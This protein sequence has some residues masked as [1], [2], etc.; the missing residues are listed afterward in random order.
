MKKI[1]N[2]LL[3]TSSVLILQVQSIAVLSNLDL[4]NDI[5]SK[6]LIDHVQHEP[7]F[8]ARAEFEDS[9][10]C[11]LGLKEIV[12]RYPSMDV[13]PFIDAWGTIPSGLLYGHLEDFGNYDECL[14]ISTNLTQSIG[15]TNGKYCFASLPLLEEQTVTPD[16]VD[17][18][19][20]IQQRFSI[21][22]YAV[23][24]IGI[25]VP[26]VC[27]SE[28][29]TEIF[30]NATVN[31]INGALKR[32]TVENC[33]TAES[34]SFN[35]TN[36]IGFVIFGIFGLLMLLSTLYDIFTD[37][38]NKP[39]NKILI[40]FSVVS[41]G[42]KLFKLNYAKSSNTISCL[43]GIRVLSMV[44]VIYCHCYT[45]SAKM[46][47]INK[48]DYFPWTKEASTM[49]VVLATVSVDSFF[50]ISGLL[51]AWIGFFE[52]DKSNGKL[53][54]FLMYFHR[55]MRLTPA[56]AAVILYVVSI[57]D[58]IGIGPISQEFRDIVGNCKN[59]WWSTL[60]Y[61]Q[62][63]ANPAD[64]CVGQT[65]YLAVDT[66]LYVLSPLILIPLWKHGKKVIP[67]MFILAFLQVGYV[68]A[69]FYQYGFNNFLG[70]LGDDQL[71]LTYKPTHA[72][73]SVW[74]VGI[75]FGY[76]MHKNRS[77]SIRLSRPIQVLGWCACFAVI[78]AIMYGPYPTIH[79]DQGATILQAALYEPFRRIGWGVMLAW[80]VFAC[81]FGFGGLINSFLSH[82]MW[83][84]IARLTYSMYL[85]HLNIQVVNYGLTKTN[86]YFS[87]YNFILTFWSTFGICL[88]VAVVLTLAFEAPVIAIEKLLFRPL[89]QEI[90]EKPKTKSKAEL[91]ITQKLP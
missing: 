45:A 77:K 63:Y 31:I 61:I 8:V 51:L 73:Y 6:I 70:V 18:D 65:W 85:V 19:G 91:E 37:T 47:Y 14:D 3:I 67:I 39:A 68:I 71:V 32:V 43:T 9:K 50:F 89:N 80:V 21:A 44:W 30:Q 87:D 64:V 20:K 24:R 42:R 52:L 15:P 53:N 76:F 11:I 55:Y 13:F 49:H 56:L 79:A 22:E 74:L 17:G 88:S 62:N 35:I 54:L 75:G 10:K 69:I 82:E 4:P 7:I 33:V 27:T 29:L 26:D 90:D 66:Q 57:D 23:I 12:N 1:L 46:P 28:I 41:N 2:L 60:L 36:Y 83:Q 72:R 58:Y 78:G 81:H 40:A 48:F 34:P 84:P 5:L 59:N 38:F 25:C 86:V 16:S